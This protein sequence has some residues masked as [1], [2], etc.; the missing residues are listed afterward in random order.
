MKVKTS[1][2]YSLKHSLPIM[3]GFF[4]VGILYG[5]LMNVNGYGF[6]WTGLCSVV[7]FAGS[8][9]YLMIDFFNGSESYFSIAMMALL[10]NCRHVFY[11]LPFIEKWS[12]YGP[13]KYLLIFLLPDETFSLDI[14][15]EITEQLDEKLVFLF[16]GIFVFLYWLVFTVSG[17][18]LGSLIPFGTD[19]MDFA[20][21][22]L[23]AVITIE[24]FKSNKSKI[25]GIIGIGSSLVC[26]LI[27]GPSYFILPSLVISIIFLVVFRRK[28]EA[29]YDD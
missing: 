13:L 19:G 5:I 29:V 21:T 23:F 3:L 11:G 4:P 27:F 15:N 28:L 7:V 2:L 10:L 9:Q 24:Q 16:N 25:P 12:E 14:S 26:L 8:L 1:I 20:L 22:A 17:S 18:L 6:Q